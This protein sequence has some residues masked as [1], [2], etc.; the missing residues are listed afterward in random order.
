MD[1]IAFE[2]LADSVGPG[3][4]IQDVSGVFQVEEEHRFITRDMTAIQDPFA[5]GGNLLM[6]CCVNLRRYHG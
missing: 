2:M 1:L 3:Q 4:Q 5:E 6:V